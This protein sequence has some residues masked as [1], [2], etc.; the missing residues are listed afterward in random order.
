MSGYAAAD[1]ELGFYQESC[2]GAASFRGHIYGI[3]RNSIQ[4]ALF[5]SCYGNNIIYFI[6]DAGESASL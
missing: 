4:I 5:L 2:A 3:D 1:R 6:Y